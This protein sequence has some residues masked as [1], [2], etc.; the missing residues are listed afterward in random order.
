MATLRD[1]ALRAGVS[2]GSASAVVNSTAPVSPEMREKVMKAVEALGY[3]PDGVARSLR[4][5]RTR[6]IGLV[7]PDI[8]NPHFAAMAS[9][10][11]V[12]CDAAG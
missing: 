5:G 6:T 3:T 10:I 9:A 2:I 11:E 8:T 1:V 12:A 7:L 4:L